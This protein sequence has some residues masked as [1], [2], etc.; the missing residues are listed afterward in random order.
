MANESGIRVARENLS[1]TYAS[2]LGAERVAGR[3]VHRHA[4]AFYVLEG[5]LTFEVGA[6]RETIRVGPGGFVG[7]PAGLAHAYGTAGDGPTGWLVIHAPDGGFAAFMRGLDEGIQT[8]W[9][10][11]P[12]PADG[13]RP[14]DHAV[15]SR[16]RAREASA[17][18]QADVGD[19][20]AQRVREAD[21]VVQFL[22]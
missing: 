21:S 18:R 2:R 14:A 22:A 4:E 15:V 20:E 3:H 1:L 11:T 12:V 17:G 7:V 10:I 5:V 16:P 6:E 9:D 13:G 8:D 19:V